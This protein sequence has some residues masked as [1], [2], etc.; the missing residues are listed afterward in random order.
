MSRPYPGAAPAQNLTEPAPVHRTSG[1]LMSH[2]P[3][4]TRTRAARA[5]FTLIELL[6]VISIIGLLIG[7]LLPALGAARATARTSKCLNSQKQIALAMNAYAVDYEGNMPLSDNGAGGTWAQLFSGY[8]EGRTGTTASGDPSEVF[9]CDERT[10]TET[11]VS[12]APNPRVIK[13]NW[14]NFGA[15]TNLQPNFDK[16]RDASSLVVMFETGQQAG[17]GNTYSQAWRIG[18]GDG[19]GGRSTTNLF[20]GAGYTV[21]YA[22]AQGGPLNAPV[23]AGSDAIPTASGATPDDG[24][25]SDGSNPTDGVEDFVWRHSGG[26]QT[27][28]YMDGHAESHNKND[29]LNRN[30]LT[31]Y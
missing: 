22:K 18:L 27:A 26:A 21:A 29:L 13:M 24:V 6:V 28:A 3:A 8:M 14:W 17:T 11:Q 20:S 12:Y 16:Q 10:I 31:D 19:A 15:G 9:L 25:W 23:Y 4:P 2:T 7:I 1:S 5:G 30:I